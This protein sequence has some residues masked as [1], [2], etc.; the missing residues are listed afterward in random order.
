MS[1]AGDVT[2]AVRPILDGIKKD[3]FNADYE[4]SDEEAMG[5]LMSQFFSWDGIA[6]LQAASHALED[7]NFHTLSAK[8]DTLIGVETR[9]IDRQ[10]KAQQAKSRRGPSCSR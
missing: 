4:A 10:I 2:A 8:V 5:I 1:M 3:Y 7:S 6:A 9:R